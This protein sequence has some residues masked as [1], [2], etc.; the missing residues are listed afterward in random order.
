M[1][2][3]NTDDSIID[4]AQELQAKTA[5]WY[6]NFKNVKDL[7]EE[8]VKKT[9]FGNRRVTDFVHDIC[10]KDVRAFNLKT[11]RIRK[12]IP[13]NPDGSAGCRG[14]ALPSGTPTVE[15][16]RILCAEERLSPATGCDRIINEIEFEV[17]LRY[18]VDTF[19]VL[20]PKQTFP[21]LYNEF[22]SFPG[23]VPFTNVQDFRNEL[24][25]IDGSC[26]AI[27]ILSAEVVASGNDC[28][29]NIIYN[30][31]D[32]LWKYENLLV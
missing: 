19:L 4:N 24:K 17:V 18:G 14:G 27:E 15:S 2:C 20:T 7:F 28:I 10:T 32:K 31:Y 1:N 22:Y 26:K 9:A 25:L 13:C 6:S 23:F 30:V 11:K 29:L 3:L 8:E 21:I 16:I 5:D 12:T